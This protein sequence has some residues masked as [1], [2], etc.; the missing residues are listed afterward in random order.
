MVHGDFA[1]EFGALELGLQQVLLVA[2]SGAVAR[3]GSFLNLLEQLPVAFEDVQ[4]FREIGEL[5]ICR[6]DLATDG[7]PNRFV[8]LLTNVC[9]SFRNF[10]LQSQFSRIGNILRDAET[11]VR[12]V[13]VRISGKR[14]RTADA[15][16]L[17]RELRIGK[18]RDL[19]R[20]LL[21]RFPS[22]PRRLNLRIVFVGFLHQGRQE[23][24]FP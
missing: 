12:E 23:G 7:T 13:A 10:A 8:L 22:L 20:H 11:D 21:R 3:V 24:R 9:V 14:S 15:D 6:F 4:C 1:Q 16:M 17:Q 19:R 2:H 18:R 5:E